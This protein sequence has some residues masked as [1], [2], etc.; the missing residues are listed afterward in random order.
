MMVWSTEKGTLLGKV[1]RGYGQGRLRFSLGG[2]ELRENGQTQ[3]DSWDG[4]VREWDVSGAVVKGTDA[5]IR[6]VEPD[7]DLEFPDL[8]VEELM[9]DS[10]GWISRGGSKWL[11]VPE[12]YG[13]DY[14]CHLLGTK[15]VL[16]TRPVPIIDVAG[17]L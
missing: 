14:R 5:A 13:W 6:Q 3:W 17:L 10:E 15:L 1:E 2:T 4:F 12:V 11:W 8:E 16:Q 9:I 7:E